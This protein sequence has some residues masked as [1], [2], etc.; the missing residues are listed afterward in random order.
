MPRKKRPSRRPKLA[1]EDLILLASV[2]RGN[3]WLRAVLCTLARRGVA[4]RNAHPE[5]AGALLEVL[6]TLPLFKGGH[7]LFDLMEWE[8]FMLDGP[9]PPIVPTVL[10]A[11]ALFRIAAFLERTKTFFDG[12]VVPEL[13]GLQVTGGAMTDVDLP[14]LEA[15]FYLYQDAVLGVFTSAAPLLAAVRQELAKHGVRR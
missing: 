2:R 3:D 11:A 15:G 12:G 4:F 14:P 9:A 7:F 8:D 10:D 13:S 1:P 6:A 5:R